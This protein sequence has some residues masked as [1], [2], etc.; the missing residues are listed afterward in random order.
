MPAAS[1]PAQQARKQIVK[2]ATTLPA[3][4]IVAASS[5][6]TEDVPA[7]QA[8]EGAVNG[9]ANVIGKVLCQPVVAGQTFTKGCFAA[10]G[11][12]SQLAA[13]LPTGMRTYSILQVGDCGT[14]GCL[15]P[16]CKVDVLVAFKIVD[17]PVKTNDG[18]S[19][20]GD[21]ITKAMS[22][23]LLENVEVLAVDDYVTVVSA[24][25]G[26]GKDGEKDAGKSV[27]KPEK[28][29]IVTLMVEVAQAQLLQLAQEHGHLSL[30]M[31]NAQDAAVGHTQVASLKAVAGDFF[32]NK[33]PDLVPETPAAATNDSPRESAPP[34]TP[35]TWDVMLIRGDKVE[36]VTVPMPA[37]NEKVNNRAK[38]D[39]ARQEQVKEEKAQD[40]F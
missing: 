14:E 3:Q 25:A 1:M 26:T 23:V 15:Y 17:L 18:N 8:P 9:A 32:E 28:H 21:T 5:I 33:T 29:R 24:P 11:S 27:A 16:G 7:D 31:R 30:A 39:K 12:S 40:A 20:G 6:Q 35:K 37:R 38:E 34:P 4:S 2:A 10:E 36:T 19:K 13:A 22:K